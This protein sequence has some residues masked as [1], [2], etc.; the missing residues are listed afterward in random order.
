MIRCQILKNFLL[1]FVNISAS[2]RGR[3]LKIVTW[4]SADVTAQDS[5]PN[6][7]NF[8]LFFVNIFVSG[9]GRTLKI[10]TWASADVTARKFLR[11]HLLTS[12]HEDL[13]PDFQNFFLFLSIFLLLV[14]VER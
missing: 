6:F 3:T 1:F 9:E 11:G 4:A 2:G 7:Q 13:L 14:K 10:V 8:F 5:L 12:P